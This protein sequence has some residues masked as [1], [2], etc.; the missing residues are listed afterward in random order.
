[1]T[2]HIAN[3]RGEDLPQPAGKLGFRRAHEELEI[4][5]R[6]QKSVLHEIGSIKLPLESLANFDPG[7]YAKVIPIGIQEAAQGGLV[8]RVPS[9]QPVWLHSVCLSVQQWRRSYHC[10]GPA[11]NT[12]AVNRDI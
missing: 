5:M 7:Q 4:P 6:L 1:M 11:R 3:L 12:A 9:D 10:N 2:H 8:A